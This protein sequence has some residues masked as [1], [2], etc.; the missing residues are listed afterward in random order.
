MNYKVSFYTIFTEILEESPSSFGD[1]KRVMFASRTSSVIV[2]REKHYQMLMSGHFWDLPQP[3]L[4]E[5]LRAKA[6]VEEDADELA[7]VVGENKAAIGSS[8]VLHYVIQP[9]AYCQLGCEYCG[10]EHA[11][12]YIPEDLMEK[13]LSRIELLIQD[14]KPE[15]LDIAWFGAEPLVGLKQIRIMSKAIQALAEKY[16]LQYDARMVTNGLSLKE[17]IYEELVHDLKISYFEITLDGTDEFHDERRFTKKGRG[18]S[19]DIIFSNILKITSRPNYHDEARIAIRCNADEQ[20][21]AGV[22]PLIELLGEHNLQDKVNFYIAAV[23]S[24]GNDAHL[25]TP[26]EE[27]AVWEIDWFLAMKENKLGVYPIPERVYSVCTA[28]MPNDEVVD[29]YGN[30]YNCTEVPLVPTYEGRYTTGHIN[31]F[32]NLIKPEDKPWNDWNDRILAKDDRYWCSG[33]K[34][35]PVCGGR[36]PKNWDDGIPPCPVMKFNMEDRLALTYYLC[37]EQ[38]S[39]VALD[40]EEVPEASA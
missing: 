15:V 36:C 10:Q 38:V 6:V 37:K 9:T 19:F 1:S 40:E 20:N 39:D 26:I 3:L 32:D 8:K 27:F 30:L 12:D 35:F 18:K 34:I 29:P 22:I 31:E 33:C 11:K 23:Y 4:E 7:E 21:A 5:L 2:I 14:R 13:T 24:W 16:N 25:R 28:V 17:K